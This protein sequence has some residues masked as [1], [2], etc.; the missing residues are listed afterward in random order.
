[1]FID[2]EIQVIEGINPT[3]NE[4][5]KLICLL[6]PNFKDIKFRQFVVVSSPNNTLFKKTN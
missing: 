4:L 2:F 5:C 6:L 3:G 1:M